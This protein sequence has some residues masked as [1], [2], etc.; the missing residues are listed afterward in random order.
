MTGE[1]LKS[2]IFPIENEIQVKVKELVSS[3][4]RDDRQVLGAP[5]QS[6]RCQH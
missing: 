2:K 4:G 3:E 1:E 5:Q 6:G